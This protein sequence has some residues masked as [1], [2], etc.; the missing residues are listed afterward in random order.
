MKAAVVTAFGES[1][2][3]LD[4]AIPEPGQGEVLVRM[5]ACGL[6]HTDIHAAQGDWPVKP[7]LPFVPGHEGIGII[8]KLGAGV[9][10]RVIGERVAIAWLGYA[11]GECRFC[12]DGRET[13]C[14]LQQNTGYSRDGAFA[15]YAVV[16]ARFAVPVPEG[17]SPA[18]AAPL[19]CAGLTTYKALK[20]AHIAPTERVAIFGIGGLGHLAVQYGRIMGGSVIAVDIEDSKLQLAKDLGAEHGINA[21]EADPV[22][23]IKDLGGADVAVV[24]A[25]SPRVFEQAFASLNRGGRLI[26]VALPADQQMNIS[27]FET[28]IRGLSIIGSI[29]GTRADLSEVFALHASGRTR[30]IAEPR[31]L[32]QINESIADVA[33]GRILARLVIEY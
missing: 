19:T 13:L 12:I 10:A 32:D 7:T 33:S 24:L 4:R 23:A 31:S 15:E 21:R 3:I 17:I 5:E 9:S 1:L 29:V 11:C 20:V 14:E 25:A 26:C 28:V 16:N 2:Q 18:D 22:A 27:I 30:I 8:E 6:C